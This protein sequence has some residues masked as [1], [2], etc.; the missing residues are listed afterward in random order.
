MSNESEKVKIGVCVHVFRDIDFDVYFNHLWCV[1]QWSRH[2]DL[3]FLGRKG[4]DA[5]T[6]RNQ[7][8]AR[9]IKEGCT[10]I[11]SM[12][13]DHLFPAE[14]LPALLDHKDE[15]M[16]SGLVCKRGNGYDQV[17][18]QKTPDGKYLQLDL[19]LDGRTY[20]VAVCAFGCTLINLKHLQKLE[21]PYF[22]DECR[23]TTDGPLYN[24][25]SD[26]NLCDMFAKVGEKCWIDTRVLVGHHGMD[27]VIFP[28]GAQQKA[29][30]D[31]LL[32]SMRRLKDN[33]KGHYYE[34]L[35]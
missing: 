16:V 5:A 11:F 31:Q 24:F 27:N 30:A 18:Y 34:G 35:C 26:I 29:G 2:Y 17:G 6:S 3:V 7:L 9:A 33:Q 21:E 32:E 14:T 25:R 23:A 22:R 20:Q 1:A 10:H 12:D 15:A 13:G 28:Q 19:P 8:A 4:L